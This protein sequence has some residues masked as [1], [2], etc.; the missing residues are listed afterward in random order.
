MDRDEM[1][2]K[3]EKLLEAPDVEDFL[4]EHVETTGAPAVAPPAA[5][6]VEVATRP[7]ETGGGLV[8]QWLTYA[9]WFWFVVSATWLAGVVVSYFVSQGNPRDD[10]GGALA[11]PL[12][13]TIIMLIVSLVTDWFYTKRETAK[14]TGVANVIMLLHIVPFVLCAIGALITIIFS[15][16]TMLLDNNPLN[17]NEGSQKAMLTAAV[18]VVLFALLSARVFFGGAKKMLRVVIW[19]VFGAV[20]LGLIIAAIAGP[21]AQANRAKHDR[22]IELALPNLSND[23]RA[24]AEKNDKLPAKLTD[25]THD[26]SATSAAVQKL[27]DQG[28][29]TYKPNTLPAEDG[30]A[31]TP[32][33]ETYPTPATPYK[34]VSSS[35]SSVSPYYGQTKRFYYQLCTT[36]TYEKKAEY[37]YVQDQGMYTAGASEGLS[38][39]NYKYDSVYGVNS[40][41]AGQVCYNLY[42]NG[43]YITPRY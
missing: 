1:P 16:V 14:K 31:Y 24:Y 34:G 8:L 41:P 36:Y 22:L 33:G 20:A 13:S 29:V 3:E 30:N 17:G 18:A 23:I 10:L 39:S 2:H 25:V 5:V 21:A 12:A 37:N 4:P 26:T 40:H 35:S 32:G 6:K 11:Y 19:A 38:A 27:I 28:L 7:P 42:A 9:F 15:L 43:S